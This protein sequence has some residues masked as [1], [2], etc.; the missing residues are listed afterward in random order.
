M[1][2]NTP[3]CLDPDSI[4]SNPLTESIGN[5]QRAWVWKADKFAFPSQFLGDPT[6]HANRFEVS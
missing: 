1:L 4:V 5:S 3:A 6:G 2:L